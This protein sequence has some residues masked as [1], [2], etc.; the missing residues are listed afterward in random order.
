[1]PEPAEHSASTEQEMP[2]AVLFLGK[3]WQ[4][5]AMWGISFSVMLFLAILGLT[6]LKKVPG[7]FQGAWEF[8]HE[9]VEGIVV[10]VMG[11][12][13]LEYFP[14][15]LCYFLYILFNNLLG[16]VP[17]MASATSRLDT[18]IALAL[19]TF[20]A[21]HVLGIRKKGF[22]YIK[23]FFSILDYKTAQGAFAK[24]ITLVLQFVLLPLIEIIGEFAR[25]LSLSMRLFGN[26]F[27][28]EMILAVLASMALDY[29]LTA[30]WASKTIMLM[31]MLLRPAVLILGVLVSIIQAVVFTA[32]SM[33]YISGAIAVHDEHEAAADSHATAH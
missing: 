4:P 33:V 22:G 25:P 12:K 30:G 20:L 2:E 1:M 14:L 7:L 28:K 13:G 21:T 6:R 26:I 17:G 8:T 27:A 19:T 5:A 10:Q 9:W 32:L 24:G 23:H 3:D 15:F 11:P 16:L 31:P 18:T 29:W